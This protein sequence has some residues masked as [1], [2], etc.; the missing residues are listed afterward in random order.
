MTQNK[1]NKRVTSQKKSSL[2]IVSNRLPISLEKKET[3]WN[4]RKSS[5]GLISALEGVKKK[6]T[7]TWI[8]WPGVLFDKDEEAF[9]KKLLKK[10]DLIPVFLSKEEEEHYYH[11]ICNGM[12]WPIFHY[13]TDK[14]TFAYNSWQHYVAVNESFAKT[15][16]QEAPKNAKIWIHDFHLMLLPQILREQRPDLKICFFLHIP[17]PSSEVYR[18]LPERE[19]LLNGILGSDY[20]GFQTSD[21]TGHFRSSCLRV[22]GLESD[23]NGLSFQGRRIGFGTHPIGIDVDQFKKALKKPETNKII[24]E[25]KERYG[26]QKL[27]LGVERLDYTKGILLKLKAFE[28]FLE[29]S[30]KYSQKVV[31]LQVLVPSRLETWEYQELK[32]EIEEMIGQLNGQFSRPGFT[33][34]Q[35]LHRHLDLSHL[36][37]L[38]YFADVGL[39]TPVR[40]GMNLVAEEFV[41]CQTEKK[42][43]SKSKPGI[44]IL[45][46]FAGASHSLSRSILV[47]PYNIEQTADAIEEALDMPQSER[48]ERMHIMAEHVKELNSPTWAKKF[49]DNLDKIVE[50]NKSGKL[51]CIL[52]NNI[53]P[54]LIEKAKKAIKR[55]FILDYDGTLRELTKNPIDAKPTKEILQLLKDLSRLPNSEV[56]VV[57]GRG[58][59]NLEDWLSHLNIFLCAEHGFKVKNPGG[60][61]INRYNADLSWMPTVREIFEIVSKEVPGSLL[62]VKACSLAWHYRM[63]D[64]DYGKWRAK[65]LRNS[66]KDVL[67]NLPVHILTGHQVVEVR[68]SGV[69][70]GNYVKD[71]LKNE[72][73]NTFILCIGDDRTD[74]EMYPKLPDYA[75]SIHVG[76]LDAPSN[77]MLESPKQVREVLQK[78][79]QGIQSES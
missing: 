13:F 17:F 78:I 32:S 56:Y 75:T 53:L 62:E 79:I 38:Y 21:Y 64:L 15:I 22:S 59:T 40:D 58:H 54:K 65:E 44:L 10:E 33:P 76:A 3:S 8:G 68:A 19:A 46:E 71:I 52:K 63:A 9:I 48:S 51:A 36:T 28:R 12:L 69:S 35:Y 47:N 23:T 14:A 30:T 70:K 66:L 60:E 5:G 50:I 39:V 42:P 16:S 4:L 61:W 29:K 67:A 49:L 18:L 7:F 1:K 43:Q 20:I 11:G 55:I 24:T 26:T 6:L 72:N 2:Y 74:R 31:L 41:F 73:K 27:L 45:S 25:L 37:A 57:S 34:I 77:Y